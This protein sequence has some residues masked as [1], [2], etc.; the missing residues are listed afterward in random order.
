MY[1][2]YDAAR[3]TI[4]SRRESGKRLRIDHQSLFAAAA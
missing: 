3:E 2:T 4:R 1:F